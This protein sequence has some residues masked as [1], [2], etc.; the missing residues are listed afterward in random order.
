MGP[1][2]Y[3][4]LPASDAIEELFYLQLPAPVQAQ[5]PAITLPPEWTGG[6]E[7]FIQ[8]VFLEDS[9]RAKARALVGKRVVIAGALEPA[10]SGHHRTSL[11]L[12]ARSI[13]SVKTWRWEEDLP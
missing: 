1:P 4:E 7:H 5:Q 12:V 6:I 11:L 2:N 9:L 3:G 13:D 10:V 8:P